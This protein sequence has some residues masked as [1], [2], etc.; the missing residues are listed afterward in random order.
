[1]PADAAAN[2][3][4]GRFK[5]RS[6][7]RIA[8]GRDGGGNAPDGPWLYALSDLIAALPPSRTNI[9]PC[10]DL[11]IFPRAYAIPA[12]VPT[13]QRGPP[14]A[15]WR[16]CSARDH[17]ASRRAL[18]TKALLLRKRPAA[19][20]SPTPAAVAQ[21]L[22][23][24]EI[25]FIVRD[26]AGEQDERLSPAEMPMRLVGGARRPHLRAD[27]ERRSEPRSGERGAPAPGCVGSP[28][29]VR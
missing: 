24:L 9:L 21:L 20:Y 27:R 18:L 25:D 28:Q 23:V 8:G 1:M 7:E 17:V 10:C 26:T 2:S 4:T 12:P 13:W 29:R 22:E 14:T 19:D 6:G 5:L 15:A 16:A 3:L 11:E